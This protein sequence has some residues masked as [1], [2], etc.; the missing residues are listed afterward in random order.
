M[1]TSDDHT[2][3]L[4]AGDGLRVEPDYR[5]PSGTPEGYPDELDPITSYPAG[6]AALL[7]SRALTTAE[8][9]GAFD[10]PQHGE[11]GRDRLGV[12]L[13]WEVVLMLGAIGFWFMVYRSQSAAITGTGLHQVLVSASVTGVL[14]LAAGLSLRAGAVNLAV[15]PIF[16]L[17][18]L[19][20]AD[21]SHAGF[22]T[23]AGIAIGVAAACGLVIGLVV[24]IFQVPAWAVGLGAMIGIAIWQTKLSPTIALTT[25]YHPVTQA[26]YWFGGFAVLAVLGGL[27]G[28]VRPIRRGL[29]RFRPVLDPALR[30]GAPAAVVT[31]LALIGSSVLAG[32]AGIALTMST[33]AASGSDGL[34]ASAAAIGIALLGGTSAFGRRGGVF[35]TFFATC[36]YTLAV[37][38]LELHAWRGGELIVIAAAIG[39][40]LLITRLV[41]RAGRPSREAL[42]DDVSQEL[43]WLGRQQ[44]SWS[45]DDPAWTGDDAPEQWRTR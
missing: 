42:A 13:L 8:L 33:G 12:H 7:P 4:P 14:A 44:G 16:V 5:N 11:P 32:A 22:T 36:L 39:I 34:T 24:T 40:G 45:Q 38:D 10:D 17:A 29:G 31:V 27:F 18:G 26:Y 35:G 1:T 3:R 20:F 37:V 6:T 15:G 41:E 2:R 19:V 30:R 23:A 21:R 43:S 28:A 25:A 9:E